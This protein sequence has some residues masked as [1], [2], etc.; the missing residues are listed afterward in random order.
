MLIMAVCFALWAPYAIADEA[1]QAVV[2]SGTDQVFNLLRDYPQDSRE[3]RE[4]I[5]AVLGKYFDFESMARLAVGRKWDSLSSEEQQRF[6]R[7]FRALLF[8]TYLGDIEEYIRK[9]MNYRTE[10]LS[11]GY[12][13]VKTSLTYQ[14]NPVSLDYYL[15]DREGKWKVYDVAVQGMSLVIN[16]RDQ[17]NSI[18]ASGSFSD[19][20]AIMKQKIARTCRLHGNC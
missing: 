11:E 18:L 20:T 16:Y 15:H 2:Q 13:V 14:G 4:N 1:P 8:S 12:A 5:E 10:T 7:E 9:N 17:F 3:R 19:L 6:T